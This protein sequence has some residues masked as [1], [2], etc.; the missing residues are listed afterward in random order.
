[1]S[2]TT[3]R[4]GDLV[5]PV[6][7]DLGLQVYDIELAGG[8]LRVLLD[9]PGGVDVD[10]L[11]EATRRISRALDDAEVMAG[12]YTLEVSSPGLERRLRTPDHFAGAVG[13]L[14]KIKLGRH[15]E[16]ERRV[17]GTLTA[18]D[19]DA[20]TVTDADGDVHRVPVADVE[21]ARTRFE[22]GPAPKPGKGG[23]AAAEQSAGRSAGRAAH[24]P[25]SGAPGRR[26]TE[27][28]NEAKR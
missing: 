9:C 20:L 22:W 28:E 4:V 2:A 3:D 17:E 10:A 25:S 8:V 16:G 7:T 1:M 24:D 23:R 11:S 12:S 13:E 6:A 19:T 15:V 26:T 21:S 18:A 5:A 14:V 27:Q